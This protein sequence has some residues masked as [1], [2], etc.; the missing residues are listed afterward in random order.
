MPLVSR[1]AGRGHSKKLQAC[2]IQPDPPL[3]EDAELLLIANLCLNDTW[4]RPKMGL[5]ERLCSMK[6]KLHRV[7][8]NSEGWVRPSSHRLDAVGV[9]S[10]V[11]DSGFGHED[12][13]FNFDFASNGQMLGYTVARPATKLASEPFGLVLATYDPS[14]W[15]AVGY[16][17]EARF[18]EQ[19]G[20]LPRHA[21]EQMAIDVFELAEEDQTA[22]R[23]RKMTLSGI[24]NTI[25]KELIY[26]CWIIPKEQ[27]FVFKNPVKIPKTV[28]N[29]G[30]QRMVT[31]FNL[32]ENQFRRIVHLGPTE[33]T[34]SNEPQQDDLEDEEGKR[35]LKLHE[36]I[37]RKARLVAKF[38][39]SLKSFACTVCAFDFQK[40]Y[41]P[42]GR[43]FIECHHIRR[44]ADMS[45]GET[46]KL[47]D[48]RAVC[49]N[50]HRMLH[51][52]SPMLTV[53]ELRELI[54]RDPR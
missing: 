14:G 15:R 41:G 40:H 16:Y 50:C 26:H 12:W 53:E 47:S 9:G 43:R 23:Y 54:K 4:P 25:Q 45:P 34:R 39:Q 18:K 13:N 44:V 21:I 11:K 46:T 42:L 49:S 22:P 10:H 27:V 36:T 35:T 8:P 30:R 48:L 51:K 29:P 3:A 32:S 28:F 6:Y 20:R 37:E 38:K 1:R 2:P 17:N 33:T 7:A 19:A 52:G 24:Q 5:L 31:S